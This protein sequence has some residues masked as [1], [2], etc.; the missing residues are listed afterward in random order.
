HPIVGEFTAH[1][2]GHALNNQLLR[3]LMDQPDSYE[4]VDYEGKKAPIQ[5]GSSKVL[6]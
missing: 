3:A 2:S 5:Y 6:L 1:K 4:I